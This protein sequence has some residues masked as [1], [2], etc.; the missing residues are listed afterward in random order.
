MYLSDI[1]TT[2]INLA[3]IPAVSVPS[4]K[5]SGGLPIGAQLIGRPFE[6]HVILHAAEMIE[7]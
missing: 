6:E 3:G 7:S 1:Y 2:S 4:G 5:S